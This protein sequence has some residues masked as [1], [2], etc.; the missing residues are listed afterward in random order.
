MPKQPKIAR[1]VPANRGVE[2]KYRKN[3][4]RLIAEMHGSIE[5]WLTAAYRKAPPRM[6][7]L[8]EQAQDASPS[9]KI[10][11]IL[12]ALS[13]RWIS[14]FEESAPKIADAY[15]KDMFKA[16]DSAMRKAL[17]DAGWTVE[18]KMTPAVRDAFNASL[19][20]NVGLI[21]SIPEKYLQ[22]VEG[23]VMRSYSNGRDLETMVKEIKQLYPGASNRAVLIAR[24]QSNKANAVVNRTRQMELGITEAI[25]L[26][27]HAGKNPR[28]DHVAANGKRYKI[29]EGCKISGEFIQPGEEINCLPGY[30]EIEFAAGCKK[31]WRRRYNGELTKIVTDSGKVIEATPNH[32]ILTRRGWIPI[33]SVNVGDYVIKIRDE[34]GLSLEANIKRSV[35]TFEDIFNSAAL[36]I[37][38]VTSSGTGFKFHGDIS[39]CEVQTINIEGFLPLE[40]NPGIC[41]HVLKSFFSKADHLL[42]G[43][44]FNGEG[45]FYSSLA[46]LFCA[47]ESIIR[48]FGALLSLLKTHGS[49]A[50]A[51]RLRLSSYFNSSLQEAA[52]YAGPASFVSLGNL[53]LAKSGFVIGNDFVIGELFQF[54]SKW[55]G[56]DESSGADSLGKI[57][58]MDP[59]SISSLT[60]IH[61]SGYEFDRVLN[62]SV[63]NF[64]GHIYNLEN[65]VNWYS[66]SSCIIHNCRCTSR[67]VLPI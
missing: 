43:S 45:T 50:D 62:K 2:A 51:I 17:K 22:Q 18:F 44:G 59:E 57:I 10:K 60:D 67:P 41:K 12:D 19:Q 7:A 8:V 26:H 3:L 49:E 39:D 29:A 32:P 56:Y 42:I 33:Q 20:E 23:V 14:R 48:S 11:K 54:L 27:S 36:Y 64:S 21:K 24:D 35:T 40:I 52:S 9:A 4:Q 55:P 6:A 5:Y 13:K 16:S 1:A 65:G 38:P 15:L 47:P 61:S 53:Q 25:W 31:L 66:S 63:S 30:S 58:R 28:P 46:R 34:I 37:R